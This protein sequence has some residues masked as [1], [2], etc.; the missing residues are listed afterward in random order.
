MGV[1]VMS[2]LGMLIGGGLSIAAWFVVS[3]ASSLEDAGRAS[4]IIVGLVETLLF[5]SSILGFVG[6]VARKQSFVQAY[7][8]FVYAHFV[9]NLV[10]AIYFLW[11]VTHFS[12]TAARFACQESISTSEAEDQCISL[13]KVLKAAYFILSILVIMVEMY[14]VIIVARYV[15]QIRDEKKRTRAS[16]LSLTNDR[17]FTSKTASGF[18]PPNTSAADGADRGLLQN[19]YENTIQPDFN[20]Y[21]DAP[22]ASHV[23]EATDTTLAPSIEV[24]YGGGTWS[25]EDISREEKERL[26]LA[27]VEPLGRL[28]PSVVGQ[29]LDVAK[30]PTGPA[31]VTR[32][33]SVDNLPRYT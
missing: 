5:L 2:A 20:P 25:H 28:G 11:V 18:Y 33:P 24:G 26:Q 21:Q 14:G 19:A 9:L 6:A 29:E 30:S 10:V 1:I 17:V 16:R 12:Q 15:N 22:R 4:F 32:R 3:T 23:F 13:V 31:F 8:Y 7:A 27:D